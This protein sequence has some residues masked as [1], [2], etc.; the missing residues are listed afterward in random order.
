[1]MR[2]FLLVL[3]LFWSTLGHS[4]TAF[5]DK[6]RTVEIIDNIDMNSL[7]LADKIES[8]ARRSDK[9]IYLMINSLGGSV[10]VG[11]TIIDALHVAQARGVEI[12]CAVGV[13]AMSMAFNILSQCD[14]RWV[15]KNTKLLFHPARIHS[16]EPFTAE[17]LV[18]AAR[19][20]EAIEEDGQ[21]QL[22]RAMRVA[23]SWFR[24]HYNR[25]TQWEAKHLDNEVQNFLTIV[26]D[27]RGTDKLFITERADNFFGLLF[28]SKRAY[29]VIRIWQP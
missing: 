21:Y 19:D 25:E 3:M 23:K 22:I 11:N 26:D 16:R 2:V 15:L 4:K 29:E 12:R 8:L 9:P 27:I 5:L 17:M 13:Y 14:K 28:G 1:M 10:L 20:L 7:G 6:K 24:Y 18:E